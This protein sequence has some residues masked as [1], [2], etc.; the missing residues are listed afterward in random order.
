MYKRQHTQTSQA[1]STPSY[2]QDQDIHAQLST[3]G[4]KV[5]QSVA[6]GYKVPTDIPSRVPLP[7]SMD[8]PPALSAGSGSTLDTMSG[9]N[10]GD[11][12]MSP[13]Q[14]LP[15]SNPGRK[16]H[17]EGEPIKL[18]RPPLGELRFDEQF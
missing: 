16:R 13:V 10:L 4:M 9:S 1:V 18:V 14:T 12:G 11:W 6:M 15:E 2:T 17:L 5:R 7:P 8:K 3:V